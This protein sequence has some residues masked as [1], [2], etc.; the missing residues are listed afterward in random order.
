MVCGQKPHCQLAPNAV[1]H[2]LFGRLCGLLCRLLC[3]RL[4]KL[5]FDDGHLR[6][7]LQ[8]CHV[9]GAHNKKKQRMRDVHISLALFFNYFNSFAIEPP[10]TMLADGGF[11]EEAGNKIKSVRL[12][13]HSEERVKKR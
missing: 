7:T 2:G 12:A 11:R 10:P 4:C 3:R 9:L 1:D 6:E 13:F 5:L 8:A